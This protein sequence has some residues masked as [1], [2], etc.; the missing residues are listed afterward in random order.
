VLLARA[1]PAAF[2]YLPAFRG[3]QARYVAGRELAADRLA[4][5]SC[6]RQPLAGAL[7]KV[8]R[9]PDWPELETAAAIGGPELLDAR[10]A[11]LETGT[12]PRVATPS[13]A[14]I[15]ASVLGAGLLAGL[16]IASVVSFGGPSAVT[17][18][19]GTDLTPFDVAT[20]V[21]C[22]APWAAAIWL[23]YRL[24]ARRARGTLTRR[25]SST[26]LT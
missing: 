25:W 5:A 7:F 9:G 24:F 11:Q 1:L 23:G 19:T 13:A 2:F 15:V 18:E 21:L 3:L 16:F 8:I 6:G 12:E 26:T 10:V 4:V 14:A 22:A 20:G 17:R